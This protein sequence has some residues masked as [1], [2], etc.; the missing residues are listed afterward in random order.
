MHPPLLS[1]R[2]NAPGRGAVVLSDAE[3]AIYRNVMQKRTGGTNYGQKLIE[4][5]QAYERAQIAAAPCNRRH[6]PR[7]MPLASI[8]G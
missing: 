3:E 5:V 1:V 8:G 2:A 6:T 4:Q 7:T